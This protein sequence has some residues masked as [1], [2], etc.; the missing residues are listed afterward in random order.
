M[1]DIG[2]SKQGATLQARSW[3]TVGGTPVDERTRLDVFTVVYF[4]PAAANRALRER[5]L[6]N[7]WR[8]AE[9]E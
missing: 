4:Y 9:Q 8:H 2:M 6:E 1:I 5:S 7:R 3:V